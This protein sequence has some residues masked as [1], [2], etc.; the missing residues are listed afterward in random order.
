M[1]CSHA[2]FRLLWDWSTFTWSY[3]R[4]RLVQTLRWPTWPQQ[5][6]PP[7]ATQVDPAVMSI[8]GSRSK[9]LMGKVSS[10]PMVRAGTAGG[11]LNNQQHVFYLRFLPAPVQA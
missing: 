9:A 2:R 10:A 8:L 7:N 5:Q 6:R 3:S 11:S 1:Y 4:C